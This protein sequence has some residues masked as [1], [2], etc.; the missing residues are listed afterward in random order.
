MRA[1]DLLDPIALERADAYNKSLS[2]HQP[3]LK[4]IQ[5][6]NQCKVMATVIVI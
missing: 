4:S 6:L 5:Y 3:D 2:Q 1:Q